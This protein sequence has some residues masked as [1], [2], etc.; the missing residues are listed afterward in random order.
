MKY[1]PPIEIKEITSTDPNEV[2]R[3]IFRTSHRTKQ[4]HY[5]PKDIESE[6]FDQETLAG[7]IFNRMA[8]GI[9]IDKEFDELSPYFKNQAKEEYF[10]FRNINEKI[11]S[12]LKF[13]FGLRD[14]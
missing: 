3:K 14:N 13:N 5:K 7:R 10:T 8:L 6:N 2:V 4:E 11:I 9:E 1:N 12:E